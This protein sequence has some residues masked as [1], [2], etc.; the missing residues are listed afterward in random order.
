[1]IKLILK[2]SEMLKYN[3]DFIIK[4]FIVK[5]KVNHLEKKKNYK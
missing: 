5:K 2:K 4:M 1:M 3:K